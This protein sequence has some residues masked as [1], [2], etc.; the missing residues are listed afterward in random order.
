M[1]WSRLLGIMVLVL[2][3][4]A[5]SVSPELHARDALF[6]IADG[7]ERDFPVGD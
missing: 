4:S 7:V 6:R 1:T 5:A 2:L 3:V